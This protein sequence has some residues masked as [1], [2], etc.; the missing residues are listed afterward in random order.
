MIKPG[1]VVML[2]FV[3]ARETKMRPAVVVS[4]ALYHGC[5]PDVIVGVLT[6]QTAKANAPTYYPLTE[7]TQ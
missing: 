6:T 5:R 7:V 2:E 4:S 1:D 3:G